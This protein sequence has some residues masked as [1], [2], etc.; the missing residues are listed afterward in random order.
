MKIDIK[1]WDQMH[2]A[3]NTV[4]KGKLEARVA[5]SRFIAWPVV[6]QIISESVMD[7]GRVL[8]YGCGTGGF[9]RHMR[10]VGMKVEG[11]DF[12]A[13][14]IQTAVERSSREIHYHSGGRETL[15]KIKGNFDVITSLMVFQFLKD[16]ETYIPIFRNL[17][18]DRGLMIF[19]VHNP[20]FVE[21]CYRSNTAFRSIRTDGKTAVASMEI[22][23]SLLIDTYV[24]TKGDY[25]RLFEK[26][27]FEYIS[28]R[29]PPFTAAF[30]S[31]HNWTLP[32]DNAEYLIMS[33]R[34]RS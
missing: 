22:E 3:F 30:I 23:K 28:T 16:F 21:S 26:H 11:I 7:K 32:S 9:C 33:L 31:E 19:T 34:K 12:S 8:D 10:T 20:D 2:H 18:T 27:G 15:D 5:D 4:K 25:R 14:M 1:N 24:R 13:A 6:M 29:Y 17:L